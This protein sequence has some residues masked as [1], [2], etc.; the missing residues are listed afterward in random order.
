SPTIGP[1]GTIYVS[2]EGFRIVAV[3]P[4]GALKWQVWTHGEVVGPPA[5]APD[6]TIY[7]QI[8][9]PPPT[10]SCADTL[11][12]CL[13]ALNPD[14]AIEWGLLDYGGF[15]SPSAGSDGIRYI[16]SLGVNSSGTC[17]WRVKPTV[18]SA[19]LGSGG[20]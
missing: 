8:D 10:G 14:G 19:S 4:D 20:T 9:D 2:D 11:N 1:D 16:D 6:G 15:Q 7:V 12:K 17:R 5:V 13:V 18:R 3:N